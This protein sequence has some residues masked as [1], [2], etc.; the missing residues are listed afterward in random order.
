M[1]T[2]TDKYNLKMKQTVSVLTGALSL[3]MI[4]LM[5]HIIF[6]SAPWKGQPGCISAASFLKNHCPAYIQ[7][8][9]AVHAQNCLATDEG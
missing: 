6:I 3:R 7:D 9:L 1:V 4:C 2:V 8:M 5:S